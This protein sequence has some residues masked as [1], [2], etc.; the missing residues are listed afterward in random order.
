MNIV[1]VNV[2]KNS[3]CTVR[4]KGITTAVF[5]VLYENFFYFLLFT[6]HR[7]LGFLLCYVHSITE[8]LPPLRPHCGEAPPGQDSNPGRAVQR[9]TNH[10][11]PPHLLFIQKL[12]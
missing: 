11:R 2:Q 7:G 1:I 10:Y 4:R 12:I 6:A 9:D 8:N 3:G 5:A